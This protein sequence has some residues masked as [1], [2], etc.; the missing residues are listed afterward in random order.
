LLAVAVLPALAGVGTS[1]APPALT[2]HVATAM[3]VCAVLSF[4]GG[5]VAFVTVRTQRSVESATQASVLQPCHDPC[6]AEAS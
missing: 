5:V 2:D 4:L 3:R 6:L 1:L